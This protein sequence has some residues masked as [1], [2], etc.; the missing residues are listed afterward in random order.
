MFAARHAWRP[1]CEGRVVGQPNAI[2]EIVI[3]EVN[4][5]SEKPHLKIWLGIGTAEEAEFL[6]SSRELH[7]ALLNKGWVQGEDLLYY[8]AEGAKHNP[9]DWAKR[10]DR[11]LKFLFPKTV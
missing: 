5:L 1:S 10:V 4:E 2:E 7:E 9:D 3:R 8:E 11:L 6:E